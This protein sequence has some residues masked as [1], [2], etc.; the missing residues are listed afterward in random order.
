MNSRQIC[1]TIEYDGSAYHG[2]QHQDNALSIQQV[3]EE[4]IRRI[5]GETVR[6]RASGRTDAGVHAL[7]QVASFPTTAKLPADAFR[8]A[9]NSTLPADIRVTGSREADPQ[10]HP[11][12]DARRK[13]Y[14]YLVLNRRDGSAVLRDRVWHVAPPLDESV[15]AESA[16]CL[17]GEHDFGAFRSSSCTARNPVRNLSRVEVVRRGDLIEFEFTGNGFLKNMVRNMVGT[18]VD[19]GLAIFPSGSMPDILTSRD[20]RKAGRC[21]PPHGLYLVSVEYMAPEAPAQEACLISKILD[22][23]EP[24]AIL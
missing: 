13:T 16:A 3:I 20:R 7:G 6:L 17:A 23:T 11:Q 21:A 8:R 12:Y 10:F 1:L 18:L 14:R 24:D 15:L 22:K 19:I 4:A 9:L 5:T 2:W